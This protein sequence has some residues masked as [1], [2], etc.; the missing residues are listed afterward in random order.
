MKPPSPAPH[1]S[2]P[3][4]D[5]TEPTRA[6]L[7]QGSPFPSGLVLEPVSR[8]PIVLRDDTVRAVLTRD[9]PTTI[10]RRDVSVRRASPTSAPTVS[11]VVLTHDNLVLNRLC[12]ESVLLNTTY[13]DYEILVVDNGSCD[14]TVGY[15]RE[16]A[17]RNPVVRTVLNE[18]NRGFAAANNQALAQASGAFIV[19][20]NNDTIVPPGWLE[21]LLHHLKDHAVGLVGP[22]TNR[23]GNWAQIPVTYRTY[24]ELL[25]FSARH[26]S[27]HRGEATD[28]QT[29]T[30]FC[31]A[32]RRDVYD[33]LGPLDERYGLG[34]FEDEDYAMAARA[35]GYRV[36]CAEDVFVHHFGQGSL[37]VLARDGEYGRLFHDNRTRFEEK[38]GV[39]WQTPAPRPNEAYRSLAARVRAAVAAEVP[40][41]ST[42]LVASRGDDELLD[43]PERHGLHF[44]HDEGGAYAGH[45]PADSITAIALL[46]EAR[47]RGGEYLL[48][49]STTRWWLAHYA[50]L[51][52]YLRTRYAVVLDAEDSC[53]IYS[54]RD[55][56]SD[57]GRSR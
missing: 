27:A 20:L 46:E 29:A 37:G 52:E 6:V 4:S 33:R 43:F 50:E 38:W 11:V 54:L 13:P 57:E 5:R 23:S 32:L 19:L 34:M 55:V 42:V 35:A 1:V 16:L 30:M 24:G 14:G 53:I 44:P 18:S 48:I 17:R 12:L 39:K 49:P 22:V 7:A 40:R 47:R 56:T 10:A 36:I 45:H 3:A 51:R 41:G 2:P 21:P 25:D 31:A 8:N 26:T 15:L 9:I 28:V